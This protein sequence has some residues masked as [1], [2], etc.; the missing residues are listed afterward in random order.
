MCPRQTCFLEQPRNFYKY[1]IF[2]YLDGVNPIR[3]SDG[4]I[5]SSLRRL[6]TVSC[7]TGKFIQPADL[8]NNIGNM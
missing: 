2:F 6:N 4:R 1:Q 3:G 5:Y 8:P 7:L